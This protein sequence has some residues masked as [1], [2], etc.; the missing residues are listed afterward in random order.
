M[1][2]FLIVD[3][4]TMV[5]QGLTSLISGIKEFT[6]SCDEASSAEEAITLLGANKYDI[7]ILD[8]SLPGMGGLELLA[9]L[10]RVAPGTPALMLS[11]FPEEQFAMKSLRLGASGYLTKQQAG[12]ELIVA[13][14]KVLSGE[15]YLSNAFSDALIT[16]LLTESNQG[17]NRLAKL[18]NREFEILRHLASGQSLKLIA[19]DLGVSI[20]TVSTYKTR[21]FE[22]MK[23]K[24][25]A[26]LVAFAIEQ[27]LC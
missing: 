10:K 4:H 23:F 18:S 20:K 27:K 16:T 15:R 13:I 3:D 26:E 12:E 11:M 17:G 8:I 2:R 5:R 1:K 7:A 24:N 22:K 6:V 9:H 21:L 19:D 25:N 14:H